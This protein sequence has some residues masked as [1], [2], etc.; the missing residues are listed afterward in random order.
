MAV[1]KYAFLVSWSHHGRIFVQCLA[2]SAHICPKPVQN[3]WKRYNSKCFSMIWNSSPDL[4]DLPSVPEGSHLLQ[5]GTSSTRAGGQDDVSSNQLPQTI[6]YWGRGLPPCTIDCCT[7]I[8]CTISWGSNY[9]LSVHLL[10]YMQ[11]FSV[12]CVGFCICYVNCSQNGL[13]A[14][15]RARFVRFVSVPRPLWS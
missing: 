2:Q 15:R 5:F 10:C 1:F 9:S 3:H 13:A 6:R 14:L 4:P 11:S 12:L 7:L 8:Q